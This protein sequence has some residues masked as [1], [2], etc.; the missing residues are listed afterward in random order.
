MFFLLG[1]KEPKSQDETPTP[2]FSHTKSLRNASE[3]IV[4]RTVSP[5]TAAPLPTYDKC[6][7]VT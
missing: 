5:K 6:I 7:F 3:K 1:K 4:V 2:I